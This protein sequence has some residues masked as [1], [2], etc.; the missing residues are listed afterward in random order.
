LSFSLN[1]I[2]RSFSRI[3]IIILAKFLTL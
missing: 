1:S 3:K 2:L